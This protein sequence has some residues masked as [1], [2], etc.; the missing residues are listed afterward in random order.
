MNVQLPQL[1]DPVPPDT[2]QLLQQIM[3]AIQQPIADAAKQAVEEAVK[4]Q[5]PLA[6]LEVA[7]KGSHWELLD[8]GGSQGKPARRRLGG[9][10][11]LSQARRDHARC[12][13]HKPTARLWGLSFLFAR[14]V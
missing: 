10:E 4:N 13:R 12:L 5:A 9:W 6:G 11:T 1:P 7:V 2:Q 8:G 3:Q 14:S